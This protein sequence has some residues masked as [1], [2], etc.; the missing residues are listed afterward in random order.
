MLWSKV[1]PDIILN[2]A[3]ICGFSTAEQNR[4]TD[5]DSQHTLNSFVS[6]VRVNCQTLK[7]MDGNTERKRCG[8]LCQNTFDLQLAA[9]QL[10]TETQVAPDLSGK[11]I[12]LF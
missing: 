3:I 6:Y 9:A 5:N 1:L 8:S 7:Y 10:H 12:S 4:C 2:A 11:L